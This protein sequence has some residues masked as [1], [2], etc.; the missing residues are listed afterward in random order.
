MGLAGDEARRLRTGLDELEGQGRDRGAGDLGTGTG[1][2]RR[3]PERPALD[4]G[5]E[6]DGR[7]GVGRHGGREIGVGRQWD[8]GGTVQEVVRGTESRGRGYMGRQLRS[9]LTVIRRRSLVGLDDVGAGLV[10][11]LLLAASRSASSH[12]AAGERA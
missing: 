4:L 7:G 12:V 6:K 10:G 5:L 9:R 1:L 11:R 8:D 2:G 3:G